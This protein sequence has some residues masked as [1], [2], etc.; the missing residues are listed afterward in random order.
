MADTKTLRATPEQEDFAHKY[1]EE[2]QGKIGGMLLDGYFNAV[3]KLVTQAKLEGRGSVTAIELG[4]GE[5]F[6]T[7]RLHDLLP[8][9]ATLQASEYVEAMVPRA[10]ANNP[11]IQITQES[12]YETKHADES[13]DVVFLLE[14]LEHLDYPD[15]GLTEI[16][17]I[18]KKDGYL[19][20]GVPREPLWCALNMARFKYLSRL[21][22]TPGHLNHWS[23][24]TLKRYLKQHFGAVVA[25]KTPLPWTLVLLQKK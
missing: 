18:L 7:Q 15:Q 11:G 1:T 2:G 9:N 8:A 23:T 10:Q 5:G 3:Q 17:R 13:F 19:I 14:V 25:T 6:S 4:C 12:I 21:G 20:L 24:F 16:S 22:N